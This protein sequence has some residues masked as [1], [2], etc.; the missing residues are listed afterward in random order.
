MP[1]SSS[2]LLRLQHRLAKR[3]DLTTEA[4]PVGPL[5]V[6][7]TRVSDPQAVLDEICARIDRHEKQT[8]QRVTS[9]SLGLPYWAELWDSSIG[10]GAY[11]VSQ[12]PLDGRAVMDL[13][14]GMGLAGTVAAMLRADVLMADYETACLGF[15]RLN[16]LRYG[17]ASAR[18]V[19][20][21][22]DDLGRKFDIIIGSDVLY[23]RTQWP[24]LDAFFRRHLAEN[25]KIL[26]G[27]PGRQSGDDFLPWLTD[28]G[29]HVHRREQKVQTRSVPIRLIELSQ[30]S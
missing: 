20:W 4:V 11:L 16:G 22:T 27:E 21:Q 23:D 7:F 9:D 29:W 17:R 14:C 15:A 1:S 6:Q 3:F 19:N 13:G 2:V 28:K 8:G 10:V 25:G 5:R 26:L 24:F 18:K 30:I 12:G